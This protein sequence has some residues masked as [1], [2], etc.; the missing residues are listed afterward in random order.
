MIIWLYVQVITVALY[1]M[2]LVGR[3]QWKGFAEEWWWTLTEPC[4]PSDDSEYNTQKS[5]K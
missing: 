2:A 5:K 4:N 1:E 3:V